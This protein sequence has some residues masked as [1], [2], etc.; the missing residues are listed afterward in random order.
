MMHSEAVDHS[1]VAQV[2]FE[3]HLARASGTVR[4]W[5][6]WK[7]LVLGGVSN[8]RIGCDAVQSPDMVTDS[9]TSS[10]PTGECG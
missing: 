4:N 8:D 1:T 9:A 7:Q 5:P 2:E 6:L 10:P 3:Q